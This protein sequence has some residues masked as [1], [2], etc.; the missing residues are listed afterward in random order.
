MSVTRRTPECQPEEGEP[1]LTVELVPKTAWG[2]NLR[3]RLP[4]REWDR[5]RHLAYDQ[6]GH[7]CEV[8]P[9]NSTK[10]WFGS[11]ATRYGST[12][13]TGQSSASCGSAPFVPLVIR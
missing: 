12:R 11:N 5:L 10:L 3:Q 1:K 8:C 4:K 2:G 6:A 13:M 7:R 9:G